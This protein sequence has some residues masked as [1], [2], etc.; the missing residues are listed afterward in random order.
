MA[1]SKKQ[2]S[3]GNKKGETTTK[4][5]G[6]K[7]KAIKLELEQQISVVIAPQNEDAS[8]LRSYVQKVF[9]ALSVSEIFLVGVALK[10]EERVEFQKKYETINFH[11]LE[12]ATIQDAVAKSTGD[13]LLVVDDLAFSPRNLVNWINN[14]EGQLP[15]D[16]IWIASRNHEKTELGKDY[17]MTWGDDLMNLLPR[18]FLGI[19]PR[20]ITAGFRFFPADLGKALFGK[21]WVSLIYTKHSMNYAFSFLVSGHLKLEKFSQI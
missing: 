1:K 13:Y 7:K 20:D 19:V 21:V 5:S 17:K 10:E 2:Q 18:T 14:N 6:S 16:K 11:F 15:E 8:T 9:A 3:K 4:K 12:E